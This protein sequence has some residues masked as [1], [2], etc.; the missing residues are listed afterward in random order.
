MTKRWVVRQGDKRTCGCTA[1][2]VASHRARSFLVATK[3]LCAPW[4][5]VAKRGLES[6]VL[7]QLRHCEC[8]GQRRCAL[9]FKR[10]SSSSS[11][12]S[13][14]GHGIQGMAACSL[15]ERGGDGAWGVGACQHLW[16]V[17]V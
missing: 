11:S 3:K 15:R 9:P 1:S 14:H 12:S 8:E 2:S 17:H 10:C 7:S 6:S 5:V 16:H 13:R 4:W